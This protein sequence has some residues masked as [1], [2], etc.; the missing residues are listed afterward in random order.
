MNDKKLI[1]IFISVLLW[2]SNSLTSQQTGYVVNSAS[3][4]IE[5]NE[6]FIGQQEINAWPS[7]F[8]KVTIPSRVDGLKQ[9]AYCYRAKEK[10]AKPLI[11]SLHT[12]SGDFQQVD[13][14][15]A[16][17]VDNDLNY[18]HPDFRGP[19]HDQAAC[20]SELVIADIEDAIDYG[21]KTAKVTPS[22]VY[23]IG[24]S[25]GGYATLCM[26]MRSKYPVKKYAA[27]VPVTDL[28][29][30]YEESSIRD[31]NYEQDILDC[32][33]SIDQLNISEARDRSPIYQETPVIRLD[34]A[35]VSIFAGVH[36]GVTG[37]VP[38][39][40]SI[41]FYNKLVHDLEGCSTSLVNTE[42]IDSLMDIRQPLG[43]F[44]RIQDRMV[45]LK[46]KF[47]DIKLV[48]FDGGHEMLSDYALDEL[49]T[50]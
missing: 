28:V 38:I 11:V 8:N 37:S 34:T 9:F 42:E 20:C 44:G 2:Q 26:L 32:T 3:D 49:L 17:C 5:L 18:I 46:K 31:N 43:D 13:P 33:G 1:L 45:L 14:I 35:K 40:H 27:W 4:S 23:I 50:E 16:L 48:I 29:A 12:W 21:I 25:G 36:D 30:W 15:A 47:G 6:Q 22:G 24:L 39:T 19:N 41:H 10:K 7:V